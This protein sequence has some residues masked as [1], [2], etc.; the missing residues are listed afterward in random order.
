MLIKRL[1]LT[2]F[3]ASTLGLSTSP[4][5]YADD[6]DIYFSD[7]TAGATPVQPNLMLILDTSGSMNEQVSGTN[8]S[9]IDVMKSA[10]KAIL[11]D[12]DNVN[13]GLMRFSHS[14]G[15]PVMFPVKDIDE[16]VAD[17]G[18]L[19]IVMQD[20]Q[21]DATQS[22]SGGG[23]VT[24]TATELDFR[25]T[26]P[27]I[28]VRFQD[29]YIPQG[30]TI[31]S[32][33]IVFQAQETD[34]AALTYNITAD[35][36]DHAP[37][38][39]ATTSNIS[40]R[41]QTTASASWAFGSW[42]KLG[43]Y[44]SPDV[45][46]VVQEV[47][48]R[49]GWCRGN[50]LAFRLTYASGAGNRQARAY[51]SYERDT[52]TGNDIH[53]PAN[54]ALVVTYNTATI[55]S[56]SSCN[57]VVAR[58][59]Q[60]TD[61]AE[62][63]NSTSAMTLTGVLQLVKT[64]SNNNTTQTVG[65]RFQDIKVPQGVTITSAR[66]EFEVDSTN[67]TATS[68]TIKGERVDSSGTFTATNGSIT[69]RPTTTASV[70]WASLPDLAA[71]QKL[72][73]PDIKTV[74]QEIVSRAG[75]AS[76]NA[77]SI[78]IT[79]SGTKNVESFDTEPGAAPLLRITYTS[80]TAP[81]E[82]VRD[83]LKEMVVGMRAEGGTPIVDALYE[84]ALYYRG[85]LVDYG[86][87]RGPGTSGS[88]AF[89][90]FARWT[91]VS[92]A[93]SHSGG[94]LIRNGAC[95]DADLDAVACED[96]NITG[97]PRYI[98]PIT[99]SC[100]T[101]HLVLLTDGDASLN[102]SAAKIK[103][104]TGSGTCS[105]SGANACGVTL[106]TFL[107]ASDQSSLSNL[108][109]VKTHTIGYTIDNT[110]LANVAEAGGGTYKVAN[111][112]AT[113]AEAFD[114]ILNEVLKNPTS[115]VSPSLSV[116]AFNKLFNR[117]EVYFSL[118]SPLLAQAW[119]GNV[120]KFVLCSD[121]DPTTG[122]EFGE[123][124]DSH[125]PAVA[126]IGSNAKIKATARSYWSTVDDGP[127]VTVGAAGS[128]VPAPHANRRVYTYTAAAD[129]PT[130]VDLTVSHIVQ[131]SNSAITETLLGASGNHSSGITERT[132]I[133]NWMRGQD[134]ED[135]D[136]DNNTTEN[137]WPFADALHSR[138][139]TISYGGTTADPVI[140]IV[141]GT[142][143][144]GLRMVNATTGEEE[145][146][147]YFPEF[148]DEQ[149]TL[150]EGNN[151]D[152][153][154]GV[155]GSPAAWTIDN[156]N[157][158]IIEYADGDRVYLYIAMRRGGRNI[159][160]F[161]ITPTSPITNS[162]SATSIKPRF[163]WRII[164]G[165]GDFAK[166]G[167]TWSQ[168]I[169][170][171]IRVKCPSGDSTCDDGTSAEDSKAKTVLIFAG[172]Y[173]PRLDDNIDDSTWAAEDDWGNAIYIVDPLTGERIWWASETGSG[174]DLELANMKYAIPSDIAMIDANS[175]NGIDR[176]YVGDTRG[177]LWRI[178][179]S[180]Q[181]DPDGNNANARNGST[182]AYVFA[183]VG[184]TG[185][186]RASNCSATSKQNRRK[187]FYP[188]D[189]AQVDDSDFSA[190]PIYDL[191]TI[192]SGD[193]EDPTDKH[194]DATSADEVH[195][196]IYAFRDIH[197]NLGG[198]GSS[199]AAL[200]DADLYDATSNALQDG[201]DTDAKDDLRAADGWYIN[202]TESAGYIGEKVLA[203][204][205]IFDG[206]LFVTT[207]VPS[208]DSAAVVCPTPSEGTARLYTLHYLNATATAADEERTVE[209]GGGIPSE[210]VVVIRE[211]G[212]TGL[213]GTSGGAAQPDI[214]S[215]LPQYRTYWYEE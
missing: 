163:M 112:A 42:T 151:G 104:L 58:I 172:G 17:T 187:F 16:V 115:F 55:P 208:Q 192:G 5:V 164:G 205:V 181:I 124:M 73:S 113:L 182:S 206:K 137:R 2:G 135:E 198:P 23:T 37:T 94:T 65:L 162:S 48:N 148:L 28:G 76:G 170:T 180:D 214:D 87:A 185:G 105:D 132:A 117:D 157:D 35:A 131:D 152:H 54:A 210:L 39:S 184:C 34:S 140:K 190:T 106:A 150:M 145:W 91:R 194:T 84:A 159:Y 60:D 45:G 212:T 215:D 62:E 80:S 49:A 31:T 102:S 88:S 22:S 82:T 149:K 127:E 95:T 109:T 122:C 59:A 197:T 116:N 101:S 202:L 168:P 96:E 64:A 128:K 93:S 81:V 100:Q 86:K 144:G 175:D 15:G 111:N 213:V 209:L 85:N 139:L 47:V 207:F 130:S 177:Q 133:I 165:A 136:S 13:V 29:V 50:A 178:D 97:T 143:D 204:T 66:L 166:L 138:P 160:A 142:N 141:V 107:S 30:V 43:Y 92:H 27:Q 63:R 188:P 155:D 32:A 118:F 119:P 38:Y 147:V 174:A 99:A 161:D 195:N 89:D 53:Q 201:T 3:I 78:I 12:L 72:T 56:S 179:L 114:D 146:I 69:G 191:I 18:S 67:N 52:A 51:E 26:N 46:T 173:D 44:E 200:T 6:T 75:W 74:V 108:Q 4:Q 103:T 171:D 24:T 183:D 21:D 196:R 70:A 7:P 79:G 14:P 158:G 40:G 1:L 9:R 10:I 36:I 211:G 33:K 126:A 167:Q 98:T 189:I 83:V 20:A 61:D 41:T 71:N 19:Q 134:L 203:K 154:Y 199:V 129:G 120:K 176:L 153:V 125:T 57:Q 193:R 11:D 25:S 186:S 110:F 77:M 68:L 169:V 121:T 123:I 90:Q 156:D 8:Q